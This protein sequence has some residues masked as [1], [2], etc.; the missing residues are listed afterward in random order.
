MVL[1]KHYIL[2][3]YTVPSLRDLMNK[4]HSV[5]ASWYNIGLELRIPQTTL[6]YFKKNCFDQ[7]EMMK[8]ML[9][10]YCT[11]PALHPLTWKAVISALRSPSVDERKLAAKLESKYC[12]PAQHMIERPYSPTEVEK[13][14]GMLFS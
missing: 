5:R 12:T 3:V 7:Q 1:I 13:S 9:A 8:R 6:D 11:T 4:L 2:L 14:D 10:E